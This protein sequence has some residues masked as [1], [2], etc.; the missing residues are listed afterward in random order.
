MKESKNK[1]VQ[2]Y[3]GSGKRNI[4][5]FIHIDMDDYPHLDYRHNIADLPMFS[6]DTVD[7]IYT[8]HSF[9]YFDRQEGEKVLKEWHRVL[10]P[11]GILRIAVPDFEAIVKIYLKYNKDIGH[12]G[13]LGPLFGRMAI[14]NKSKK[15]VI[16]HKTTY[17]FKSLK[18]VLQSAGFKSIHKYNWEKTIHKDYDDHSQAYIPHLDKKKGILISLNLEAIKSK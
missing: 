1:K 9:E 6:D 15:I 17:D 18:K 4:P 3:L 10:K 8:S 13:I 12:K 11:E 7:L 14:K 2:L 5:G 16:Y